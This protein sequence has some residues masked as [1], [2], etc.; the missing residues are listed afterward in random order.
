MKKKRKKRRRERIGKFC[1][2]EE[3]FPFLLIR[4]PQLVLTGL[5]WDSFHTVPRKARGAIK[6]KEISK[7]QYDTS[8]VTL[9][10]G[11]NWQ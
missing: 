1:A 6:E 5:G 2:K 4:P 9:S 11:A 7:K 3:G 8:Q 10:F